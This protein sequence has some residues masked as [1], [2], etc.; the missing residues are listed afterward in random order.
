MSAVSVDFLRNYFR[1]T[2][3]LIYL[4]AIRNPKSKLSPG[5]IN[6]LLTRSPVDVANFVDAHDKPEH[7]CAIYY[8]TATLRDNHARRDAA[9]CRQFPSLFADVDDA[10]HEHDRD[11]V[12]A[13]LEGIE[14]PPTMIVNSGHG[15][16]PHWLLAEPSENAERVIAARKKLHALTA[17]DAVHDAPRFMRLPGSHNSKRGDWL[18]VELVARHPERRYAIEVLEEWLDT[19]AVVISRKPKPAKTNGVAG[20]KPFATPVGR[21]TDHRR[22][23][24]WAHKAL[25]ESARELA[26]AGEGWRHNTLRDKSVRLGTM[27]ARGWIDVREVRTALFAASEACGQIKDYGVGHFEQTLGSGLALGVAMPHPDL[28]DNEIKARDKQE[29]R[30]TARKSIA[31]N[32]RATAVTNIAKHLLRHYV[33]AHLAH[34]LVMAWN[35]SYCTP[36]LAASKITAIVNNVAGREL[37]RRRAH[38]RRYRQY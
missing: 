9:G 6:K 3:G 13:L 10:N 20:G 14:C 7:E 31:E 26:N 8:C 30:E 1:G 36:P 21:G 18:P 22:G 11:R 37:A 23:A 32:S 34:G 19:A 5:E 24:A 17:S 12:I 2:E 33:D 35:A 38:D 25:E 27:V 15:L 29:W 4:A 16:Q 28:P